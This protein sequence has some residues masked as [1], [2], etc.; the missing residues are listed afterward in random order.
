MT[1][2]FSIFTSSHSNDKR[3]VW[4][5]CVDGYIRPRIFGESFV[6]ESRRVRSAACGGSIRHE[7]PS[8][9][10]T[11]G[12]WVRIPLRAWMFCECVFLCLSTGRGLA[13][14]WSPVQGV[15]PTLL[16]LVT[17]VN[18]KVSWRRPRPELGCRAKGKNIILKYNDENSRPQII[19]DNN[20]NSFWCMSDCIR[21]LYW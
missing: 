14:S 12:P 16:D 4:S 13:T 21:D 6:V 17:E 7:L 2:A 18:R 9:A 11:P 20:N 1:C 8:L 19:M 10:R 15:L 3:A 5:R